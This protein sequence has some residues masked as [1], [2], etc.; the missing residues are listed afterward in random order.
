MPELSARRRFGEAPPPRCGRGCSTGALRG[1]DVDP[2]ISRG[3]KHVTARGMAR[4]AT[5]TT[6]GG[7]GGDRSV[8][9]GVISYGV[10][11][12]L[13]V[14][15]Q[16]N[17]SNRI[18]SKVHWGP[19]SRRREHRATPPQ[20]RVTGPIG[21]GACGILLGIP[22]GR[23]RASAVPAPAYGRAARATTDRTRIA[24]EPRRPATRSRRSDHTTTRGEQDIRAYLW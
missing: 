15:P 9:G 12:I 8:A 18:R 2:G 14:P 3:D 21:R 23:I 6:F 13:P 5:D 4:A 22:D 19:M 10:D 7:K 17:R 20:N 24:A 16:H 1:F 11:S